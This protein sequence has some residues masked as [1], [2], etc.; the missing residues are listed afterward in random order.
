MRSLGG[1]KSAGD[2]LGLRIVMS[3]IDLFARADD[4][5]DEIWATAAG[6]PD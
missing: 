1:I 3:D 4:W 2:G 5:Q 6:K